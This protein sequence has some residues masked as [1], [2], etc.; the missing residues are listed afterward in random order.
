[1]STIQIVSSVPLPERVSAFAGGA[2]GSKYPLSQME[3]GQAIILDGIDPKKSHSKL[4]SAVAN[5][6]KANPGTTVK[7]TV[8]SFVQK[9]ESGTVDQTKVGLWRVE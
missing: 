6:R 4:A 7:F 1:M 2:R 8:R 9:D 5:F 3:V